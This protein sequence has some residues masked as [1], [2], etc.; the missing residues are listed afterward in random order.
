MVISPL[1]LTAS[2]SEQDDLPT[3]PD[4]EAF[5]CI[6]K[7]L[8][9]S[10]DSIFSSLSP[11]PIAAASLGQVYK[12][13]LKRSGQVVA[14]KVQRPNIEEAIGLDFYLI[15]SLGFLINKY[16]DFISSDVVALIDEFA[17]RVYQELNYVQVRFP[18]YSLFL[19]PK[20]HHK[21]VDIFWGSKF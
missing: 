9:L 2:V 10:L 12:G 19:F 1:A 7:E 11:S 16:V 18:Y 15:R 6:E 17:R 13:K 14:V 8:A 20:F 5:L 3:F 4:A 21:Y